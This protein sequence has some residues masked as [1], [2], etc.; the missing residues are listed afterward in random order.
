M[1]FSCTANGR[2]HVFDSSLHVT[3]MTKLKR[4]LVKTDPAF[5]WTICQRKSNL[6][7][8]VR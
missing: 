3:G 8:P 1:K 4:K 7:L 2:I 5:C 6:N